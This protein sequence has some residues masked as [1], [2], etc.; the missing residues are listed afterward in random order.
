MK[1]LVYGAGVIGSLY[2][3]KLQESGH[4]VTL[5]ARGARL[6]DVRRHGLVLDDVVGGSRLTIQV[7]TI[8]GLGADDHYDLA[9]IAVRRDQLADVM[10]DLAAN[11][12]IPMMLF[13]MNNPGGSA[14]LVEALGEDRVLLGFPGAGG[15]REGHVIRYAL[16]KQQ[17]TT[18]GEVNG[19]QTGRLL[20]VAK[21]FRAS[22]FPVAISRD[23][24]SWLKTHAFFVTAIGGAIYLAGADCRRLSQDGATL[25]LMIMGVRE[26]FAALRALGMNITPFP[27]MLLFTWMP[28]FFAVYYWRRFFAS[29]IA[30]YVVDGH[31]RTAPEEMRELAR[32][33]WGLLEKSGVKAPALFQ[34][35][36]AIDV[37]AGKHPR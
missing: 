23:M 25:A 12:Q 34:L 24:D 3:A 18:L 11:R 4:H 28:R 2:T 36:R 15:T 5:L 17:P 16:I 37:Y 19:R 6:A 9:I 32:D 14:R 31:A 29:T 26:G 33:C 21:A 27:L 30:D 10:P 1:I 20:D 7:D 22:G 13:M 35:Y 8:E